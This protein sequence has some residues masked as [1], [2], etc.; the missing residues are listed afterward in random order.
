VQWTAERVELV[1]RDLEQ[2]RGNCVKV[3]RARFRKGLDVS[4]IP[5]E[6]TNSIG[7]LFLL[8]GRLEVA[9]GW[10]EPE[11]ERRGRLLEAR[12]IYEDARRAATTS[13]VRELA[14]MGRGLVELLLALAPYPGEAHGSLAIHHVEGLIMISDPTPRSIRHGLARDHYVE[15][16]CDACATF[17][18]AG[19][20]GRRP[21]TAAAALLG[22]AG[23]T[24]PV[25]RR[26]SYL[27]LAREAADPVG[28]AA[29]REH[30]RL[31]ALS[32]W[33]RR[34][35]HDHQAPELASLLPVVVALEDFEITE[36]AHRIVDGAPLDPDPETS[37]F[38]APP[39]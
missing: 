14:V 25:R 3:L 27:E 32:W 31:S 8:W 17:A 5:P 1:W 12:S 23:R 24:L 10:L 37:P 15:A 19:E 7:E 34:F 6:L 20:R 30:A 4:E 33:Q 38:R 11:S 28:A 16:L 39:N 29:R 22:C 9:T 35:G 13:A 18:A 36:R 26:L 21:H 2:P